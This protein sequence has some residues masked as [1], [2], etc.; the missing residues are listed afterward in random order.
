MKPAL[1][2]RL[3]LGGACLL[4]P[5]LLATS[6]DGIGANI[7]L[8]GKSPGAKPDPSAPVQTPGPSGS[9]KLPGGVDTGSSPGA[10]TQPTPSPSPTAS[11]ANGLGVTIVPTIQKLNVPAADPASASATF[12]SSY[13]FKATVSL[14][15]GGSNSQVVWTSSDPDKVAVS[16][17]GVASVKPDAPEGAVE[18][19]AAFMEDPAIFATASVIVT[20]DTDFEFTIQ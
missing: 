15:G 9:G 6:C 4:L 12:T 11:A 10:T 13:T 18:I 19:R 7:A 2:A 5:L 16:T 3:A 17:T 8:T 14:Q 1:K 20:R